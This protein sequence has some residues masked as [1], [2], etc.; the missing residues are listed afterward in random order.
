MAGFSSI[1]YALAK[2]MARKTMQGGGAI[3]GDKGDKGDAGTIAINSVKTLP[4]GS[5]ATVEN[6]GTDSAAKLNIGIPQGETGDK[7]D[8]GAG[9]PNGGTTGQI[10]TKKSN[11]DQDTE[12]TDPVSYITASEIEKT[13]DLSLEEK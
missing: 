2:S 3:K 5:E 10:L 1:T 8:T 9:V 11:D 7:G 12:W 4:A 6:V 13:C